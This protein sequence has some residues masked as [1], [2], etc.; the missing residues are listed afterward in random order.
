[1]GKNEIIATED[2]PLNETGIQQEIKVGKDIKKL[3]IDKIFCSPIL[4]EKHT[5]KYLI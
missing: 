2:E 1:M 3:N 5:L 4:R